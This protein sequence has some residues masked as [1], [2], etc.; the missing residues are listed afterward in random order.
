MNRMNVAVLLASVIFAAGA[1]KICFC[2]NWKYSNF[3]CSAACCDLPPTPGHSHPYE[4]KPPPVPN[5]PTT[6]DT[7]TVDGAVEIGAVT[8]RGEAPT[9]ELNKTGS[10]G[11]VIHMSGGGWSFLKNTSAA[12]ETASNG[13]SSS[14][15]SSF[16]PDGVSK[17][18][19]NQPATTGCYLKCD[20]IMS[21]DAA[22]NPLFH[23]YNKVFIPIN[24]RTSFTGNLDKPIPAS[25]P[26]KYVQ[27]QPQPQPHHN[28][29]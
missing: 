27:P 28:N 15:I 10:K 7:V 16:K 12:A 9:I 26:P 17:S 22:Q 14:S 19:A 3:N 13:A 11:W 5:P 18:A 25:V 21:T 8:P 23:E 6:M 20:G 24:D 29:N 4:C 1:E 2:P